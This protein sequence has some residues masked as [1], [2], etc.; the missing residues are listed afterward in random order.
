MPPASRRHA[1]GPDRKSPW[2]RSPRLVS[3]GLTGSTTDFT[4]FHGNPPYAGE[5]GIQRWQGACHGSGSD[6][7]RIAT[8]WCGHVSGAARA[9]RCRGF[10]PTFGP[11]EEDAR[12]SPMSEWRPHDTLTTPG[13]PRG[14]PSPKPRPARQAVD[15]SALIWIQSPSHDQH[16]APPAPTLPVPPRRPLPARS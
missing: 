6:R 8:W 15:P 2:L 12:A 4:V 9:G 11:T 14:C 16:A 13:Q 1:D 5:H 3:C 7:D 10:K